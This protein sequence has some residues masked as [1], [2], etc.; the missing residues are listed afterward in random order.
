[1]N[2]TGLQRVLFVCLG[3]I[4]RSA[5]AEGIMR[6]KIAAR[7]L[8]DSFA[9]DSAGFDH[10]TPG[11]AADDRAVAAA[12]RRGIAVETVARRVRA[13][14][15]REFDVILAM[16]RSNLAALRA[17]CPQDLQ[18]KLHLVREFDTPPATDGQIADPYYGT[19]SDF[20]LAFEILDRC[21]DAI[22]NRN[23]P[24]AA[25]E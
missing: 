7:G 14:D 17:G 15:Y 24:T 21:T 20:E 4:C 2:G 23:G 1:M 13:A 11:M 5:M 25:G 22:I 16:D 18:H 12:G 3:N 6:H 19:Q 9:C 10:S 8:T